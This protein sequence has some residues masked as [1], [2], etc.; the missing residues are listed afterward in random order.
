MSSR[1]DAKLQL[2]PLARQ[3]MAQLTAKAKHLGLSPADFAKQLIEEGL[4]LQ[5]EAEAHSLAEIMAP[6]RKSAGIVDEK[7]I[8]A[9]VDKA[10]GTARKTSPRRKKR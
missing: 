7:E 6:V 9:L 8:V 10:R 4:E 1:I 5:H 2:P 3:K